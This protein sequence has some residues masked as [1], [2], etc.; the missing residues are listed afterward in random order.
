MCTAV[1][2][3]RPGHNWPLL[4]AGNRD[5]MRDRP[6]RGPGRHWSDRPEVIGGLDETA[7]G[8]W[9]GVNE[10]GVLSSI[11]NRIGSL[12]PQDGKRSRGEL[13]LEALDHAE[14]KEA[15]EA[16][17][18][19][20]PQAYRSFNLIIADERRRFLAAQPG[21]RRHAGGRMLPVA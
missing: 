15:A 21:E 1:I 19:L 2:L 9:L 11:L 4:F 14:A 12:G 17:A 7:G 18:N 10:H 16:L 13:V 5:E 6:A 8:T 20:D 3:R